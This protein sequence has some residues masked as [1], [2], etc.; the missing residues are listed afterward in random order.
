M[1]IVRVFIVSVELSSTTELGFGNCGKRWQHRKPVPG[2]SPNQDGPDVIARY[3]PE[4]R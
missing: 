2:K 1:A 4:L 3:R